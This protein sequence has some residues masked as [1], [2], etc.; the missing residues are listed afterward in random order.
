MTTKA[1]WN[2]NVTAAIY[3]AVGKQIAKCKPLKNG[4]EN[5]RQFVNKTKP[6]N[7]N[8]QY[9]MQDEETTNGY[10]WET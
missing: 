9:K 8:S 10:K 7:I 1:I 4:R 2:E 5:L 6:K 3:L